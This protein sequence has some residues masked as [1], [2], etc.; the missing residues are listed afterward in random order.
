MGIVGIHRFAVLDVITE[1]A[2]RLEREI[3]EMLKAPVRDVRRFRYL[4]EKL[5]DLCVQKEFV[6]KNLTCTRGRAAIMDVMAGLGNYTGEITHAGLGTSSTAPTVSDTQLGAEVNRQALADVDD[7]QVSSAIL[8]FSFF[9]S[10]SSFTN[11]TVNEFGTF[12]D[13][14][15][16]ANSGRILTRA[17]FAE[18]IN[19]TSSKAIS[20]D[21]QYTLA[22]A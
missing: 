8:I 13:A 7:T 5:K 19:K 11:S 14:T 9:W 21:A 6:I 17:L 15:A 12:I 2:I 3:M 20:C 18:T 22:N 1:K 10:S 16:T 4:R